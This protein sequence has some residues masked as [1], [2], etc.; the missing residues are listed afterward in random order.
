MTPSKS[1]K[2]WT[3]AMLDAERKN[4][5]K[6]TDNKKTR[7]TATAAN[8][9][10][11]SSKSTS[12]SQVRKVRKE[13]PAEVEVDGVLWKSVEDSETR[14]IYYY[15]TVTRETSWKVPKSRVA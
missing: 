1:R 13:K 8:S 12:K 7:G 4:S 9:P 3:M 14:K 15:N 10:K 6:H 5:K 2:G 11:I